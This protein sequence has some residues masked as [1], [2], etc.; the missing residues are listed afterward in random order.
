MYSSY[1]QQIK[2]LKSVWSDHTYGIE[3]VVR[4]FLCLVQFMYPTL[5]IRDVFGRLGEHLRKLAVEFYLILKL[6]FPLFVLLSGLYRHNFV[7][8]IIAY[9]LSETVF[10]ILNL[11]FLSDIHN[12]PVSYSR[13]L[14]FLSIHYMETVFDFAA[15]YMAFDLLNKPLSI[16][17]SV[18]FSLVV[19]TTLGFGEYYPKEGVGQVVVMFQL[20]IFTMF[21]ILFVNYF[22]SK[23]NDRR[24]G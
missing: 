15:I 12:A 21:V 22:S 11:V 2:S 24:K 20:I 7:I 9:L 23:I 5:L 14:L 18:Y 10:H 4:L 1:K 8:I 17:S 3:R 19:N 13:S 16:L 6:V